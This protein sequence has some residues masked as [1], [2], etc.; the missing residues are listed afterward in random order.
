MTLTRSDN[1]RATYLITPSID[2]G[3][4]RGD[5]AILQLGDEE[6]R[7]IGEADGAEGLDGDIGH[8]R[9]HN[10]AHGVRLFRYMILRT[11]GNDVLAGNTEY[12]YKS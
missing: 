11:R 5:C 3:A 2:K 10:D 8:G 7:L 1:P 12:K 6:A 4:L 9:L